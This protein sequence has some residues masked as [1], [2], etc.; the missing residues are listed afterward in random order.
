MPHY[1]L[2]RAL[3]D[4]KVN[5]IKSFFFEHSVGYERSHDFMHNLQ[6]AMLSDSFFS[7]TTLMFWPYHSWIDAELEIFLRRANT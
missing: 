5:D 6:R 7:V 4:P 2:A 3:F 1:Q